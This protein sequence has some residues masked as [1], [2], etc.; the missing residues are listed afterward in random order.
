MKIC[1]TVFVFLFV[2]LSCIE[3]S[4]FNV[5]GNKNNEKSYVDSKYTQGTWDQF[6]AKRTIDSVTYSLDLMDST[7]YSIC[8][9][10]KDKREIY[11]PG[12]FYLDGDE[13]RIPK[14]ISKFKDFLLVR[15]NLEKPHWIGYF[16]RFGTVTTY[17]PAYDYI[18]YDLDNL[19]VAMIDQYSNSSICIYDFSTYNSIVYK[20]EGYESD[21][22]GSYVK[23]AVF[24]E[25]LL[26]LQ[27]IDPHNPMK[28]KEERIKFDLK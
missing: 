24:E 9:G 1:K 26:I 11:L 21:F 2:T 23:S 8:W 15:V 4:A 13:Y 3:I 19:I 10:L 20:I 12:H 25:G 6:F 7:K 28:I 14:L 22:L 5:F 16:L 27:L 18:A 17:L